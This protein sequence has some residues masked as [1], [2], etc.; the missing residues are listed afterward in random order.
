MP[1]STLAYKNHWDMT[2]RVD[3]Y[4]IFVI[5]F[6]ILINFWLFFLKP[7][8]EL[9]DEQVEGLKNLYSEL[10]KLYPRGCIAIKRVPLSFVK[11]KEDFTNYLHN[12]LKPALRKGIPSVFGTFKEFYISNSNKV[13]VIGETALSYYNSLKA[14]QKFPGDESGTLSSLS[15]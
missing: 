2:S 3:F 15:I 8:G 5:C 1:N 14:T 7:K 13:E 10:G 12:Y 6:M 4:N 9:T 11:S